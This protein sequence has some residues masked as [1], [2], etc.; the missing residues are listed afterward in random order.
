MPRVSDFYGIAIYLYY[1]DHPPPHFHAE[2]VGDEVLIDIVTLEIIRGDLRRRALGLVLEWAASHQ[3]ELM[4]NWDL[5]RQGL[6]LAEIDG[7]E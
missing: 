3:A 4:A 5:A 7:L 1:N 2:H 6:P